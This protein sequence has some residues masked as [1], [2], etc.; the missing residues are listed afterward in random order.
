MLVV[1][2]EDDPATP[3]ESAR[4]LV[5]VLGRA[6]LLTAEGEQHTSFVTAGNRCV[7]KVVVRYLVDRAI[8]TASKRC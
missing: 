7:D 5:H 4:A 8:P 6:T 2:T 1:G 3:L